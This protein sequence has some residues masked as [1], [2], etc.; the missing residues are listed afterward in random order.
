MLDSGFVELVKRNYPKSAEKII[1]AY[2]FADAAHKDVKR[3]SGE[4]YITHPLEVAK[5]LIDINMDYSTIMAGLLHDVVEDT[6]ISLSDI[7]K[8]FGEVVAKLVDGVT[9]LSSFQ[10]EQVSEEDNLKR[11]LLAMGDDIRVIFIK[12]ADRLHN[13]R[14]ISYLRR[15][16]QVRM[17]EETLE[18]FIPIAERIGIRKFRSEMQNLTLECLNG[19]EYRR[20]KEKYDDIYAHKMPRVEQVQGE[21]EALMKK[22]GLK[23]KV[24]F[25]LEDY[26]SIYKK[27]GKDGLD[28]ISGLVYFK[29]ILPSELDCYLALG[30]LHK[31][32]TPLPG[33]LQDYIAEPKPNGYQSLQSALVSRNT[34][35]TIKVM[36][37]TAKMDKICEYGI[38]S[39]WHDKDSDIESQE[40]YEKYNN[41]KQIMLSENSNFVSSRVF[42]DAIRSD[43]FSTSTWVFTPKFKAIRLGAENP[44]AIDFAYAVHSDI[45]DNS[46]GAIINGKKM[47]L[48][49]TLKSGD[50]VEIL[51][52]EEKK[53]PS[54]SWINIAQTSNARN[55]IRDY[56]KRHTT[57][58]YVKL[59]KS[60]LG[61]ALSEFGFSVGD[62]L[63][64]FEQLKAEYNFV[65]TNDMFASIG[66]KSITPQQAMAFVIEQSEQENCKKSSPVKIE[67]SSK[68]SNLNFARCCS[69]I[70]GDKIVGVLSRGGVTIHTANCPNLK[71]MERAE[72]VDAEWKSDLHRTFNVNLKVVATDKVGLL[73]E[74]S[75][76]FALKGINISKV[77][78][79]TTPNSEIEMEM[80]L[81]ILNEKQLNNVTK[82]LKNLD[83][84]KF[85]SRFFD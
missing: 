59:G 44:T 15:D 69:A 5:I 67:G 47:P 29:V 39:L 85:V 23:A 73:S 84:V 74:I 77:E 81:D 71:K 9:K 21:I 30:I 58:E 68:F 20:I 26:Y 34:N 66:Y 43:L 63:A 54:R 25:W 13:M 2:A 78:L 76:V 41:L 42:V 45:G 35:L 8:K 18:I 38:A 27:L 56:I 64:T 72:I 11:L 40:K 48:S 12:L 75:E 24:D 16:R 10:A 3:R 83:S 65:D 32:F 46:V 6:D 14:T 36:L 37:R 49:T 28:K 55:K 52:S 70:P 51:L 17:A 82:E 62:V 7:A 53:A 60:E 57:P 19:E 79:K 33:Q 4:P 50:V 80:S 61:Q 1:S 22:G 31:N